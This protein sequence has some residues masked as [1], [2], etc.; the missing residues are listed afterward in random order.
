MYCLRHPYFL[1]YLSCLS[2]YFI[3]SNFITSLLIYTFPYPNI[4]QFP[5]PL[6]ST[7]S[8]TSFSS[9][10]SVISGFSKD[11]KSSSSTTTGTALH[12]YRSIV[13]ASTGGTERSRAT[14]TGGIGGAGGN[15]MILSSLPFTRQIWEESEASLGDMGAPTG[16]GIGL[17][18]SRSLSQVCLYFSVLAIVIVVSVMVLQGRNEMVV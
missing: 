1:F 10:N 8:L 9:N 17:G 12:H 16:V 5:Q 3:D 6:L 18:G 11:I 15:G 4:Y 14:G 13:T 2:C 7:E